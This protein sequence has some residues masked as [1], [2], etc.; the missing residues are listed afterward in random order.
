MTLSWIVPDCQCW[1]KDKHGVCTDCGRE[2]VAI[3]DGNYITW[4]RK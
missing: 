1:D 2:Y 4:E 3:V